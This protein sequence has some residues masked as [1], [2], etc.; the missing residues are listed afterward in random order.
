MY[1]V[2]IVE[3]CLAE[4]I[5][6]SPHHPYTHSLGS[7]LVEKRSREAAC[8]DR[9]ACHGA[10]RVFDFERPADGCRFAPRRPVFEGLGRPSICIDPASPLRLRDLDAAHK[11]ACHFPLHADIQK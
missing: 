3:M 9:N 8:M 5:A 2:Q 7:S 6:H 10:W 11:V 4:R 1:L